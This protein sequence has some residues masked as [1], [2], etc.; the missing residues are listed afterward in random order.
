MGDIVSAALAC[1]GLESRRTI[2]E[3]GAFI[4]QTAL[5]AVKLAK[6]NDPPELICFAHAVKEHAAQAGFVHTDRYI[7]TEEG[8]PFA[9]L[10]IDRYIVSHF[11]TGRELDFS[12]PAEVIAAISHIARFHA[13]ARGV[14]WGCPPAD[15]QAA[16]FRQGAD[17]LTQA[18]KQVR[19]QKQRSDFDVLLIKNTPLYQERIA[20]SLAQLNT[21]LNTALYVQAIEENHICHNAL[22][23]EYLLVC[24][25]HIRLTHFTAA[26]K[27]T[28]L[29]DLAAFIR[30]YALRGD[31]SLPIP[32][33][34]EEY[35]KNNPLPD[36]AEGILRALLL[37]P[38][39]FV[40]I[41]KQYYS[42]K[43]SWTP[44]G[45]ISRMEAVLA[46]QARYDAFLK[47]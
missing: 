43:R 15:T 26:A 3:K 45:L 29:N 25:A 38:A 30:R 1:F 22:K 18:V 8:L 17:A 10:G 33:I 46:E 2:K 47:N 37:Y 23:E 32:R 44:A 35:N 36:G 40:K 5:G 12:A 34:L 14:V 39:P 20:E 11:S 19:G 27:D 24:N 13:V 21:T 16:L 28:Q 9:Q 6:T 4:C 42:K 7:T 31:I 41:V